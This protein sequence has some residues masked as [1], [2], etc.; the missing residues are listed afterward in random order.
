MEDINFKSILEANIRELTQLKL[1]G[2][3]LK[4]EE[5][6]YLNIL[7]SYL[8]GEV[9][10]LKTIRR[11]L[12]KSKQNNDLLA[13]L[14]IRIAIRNRKFK[15]SLILDAQNFNSQHTWFQ[16]ELTFLSA[17]FYS[18]GKK[19]LDAKNNY[20]QAYIMF[21]DINYKKKAIKSLLN[22]VVSESKINPEKRLIT[23]YRFIADEAMKVQE[24]GMAGLCNL[25]I[26]Q[27]YFDVK[28]LQLSLKYTNL[29]IKLLNKDEGSLHYYLALSHRSQLYLELNMRSHALEDFEACLYCSF[30]EIK[31]NLKLIEKNYNIMNRKISINNLT[32]QWYQRFLNL[33]KH[34]KNLTEKEGQLLDLISKA[35]RDKFE[36]ITVLYPGADDFLSKEN[37]F[38]VLL[39]RLKKKRPSIINLQN[40]KY[41][42]NDTS[43]LSCL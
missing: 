34:I 43:I 27:E 5:I 29:A 2:H 1:E 36:L 24:V 10:E 4:S 28:S 35:P 25:N 31:E 20:Y 18:I 39:S 22:T 3:K 12:V 37:R 14:D 41:H 7:K 21:K 16:A 40:K 26:A 9:S 32:P 6:L 19:Y 23:D 15:E 30:P 17:K 11:E 13:L 38:K 33:G 42:F 8:K